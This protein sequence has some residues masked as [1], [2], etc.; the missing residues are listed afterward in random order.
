MNGSRVSD[1]NRE[2]PYSEEFVASVVREFKIPPD[3]AETL[4]KVL[5][6][7]A[8][9]YRLSRSTPTGDKQ[10]LATR[11]ALEQAELTYLEFAQTL[12]SLSHPAQDRLWHPMFD[13]PNCPPNFPGLGEPFDRSNYP[14]EKEFR[15]VL[16]SFGKRIRV[17]LDTFPAVKRHVGRRRLTAL[18]NWIGVIAHFWANELGWKFSYSESD[19]G[20]P[21]SRAYDF[22]ARVLAPIDQNVSPQQLSTAIRHAVKPRAIRVTVH[23]SL[24]APGSPAAP[25]STDAER[26]PAAGRGIAKTSADFEAGFCEKE[27][28]TPGP[29]ISDPSAVTRADSRQSE[30]ADH[31]Q[32]GNG[33]TKR[34][35]DCSSFEPS[36]PNRGG[37]RRVR[38]RAGR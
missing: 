38:H 18:H 17:R 31:D 7:G 2:Q 36:R 37:V 3:K 15:K 22:C 27:F 35:A 32:T 9:M 11:Q 1:A 13:D 20:N 21:K 10:L 16:D 29:L 23:P 5:N 28:V 30:G 6:K 19:A 26:D 8:W 24:L 33:S 14:D 4:R 12:A 25:N 34:A